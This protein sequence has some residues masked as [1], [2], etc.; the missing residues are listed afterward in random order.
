MNNIHSFTQLK[1]LYFDKVRPLIGVDVLI[2]DLKTQ[3][4][5]ELISESDLSVSERPYFRF[6]K[7]NFLNHYKLDPNNVRFKFYS[8]DKNEKSVK[9]YNLMPSNDDRII[10]V[11]EENV[12]F[13][14]SNCSLLSIELRIEKGVEIDSESDCSL[15]LLEYLSNFDLLYQMQNKQT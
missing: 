7:S 5:F 15:K 8:I 2:N 10:I 11:I 14:T 12:N 1:N 13:I 9:Y 3:L 4:D 6:L